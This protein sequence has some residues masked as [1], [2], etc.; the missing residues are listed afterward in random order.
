MIKKIFVTTVKSIASLFTGMGVTLK[1]FF[2]KPVTMQYPEEKVPMTERYRGAVCLVIDEKTGKHRCIACMTCI[3]TC[4]NYS[5]SL[6]GAVDENKKR[7]PTKFNLELGQ[8]MFCG[9]C[10]E[11]CPTKAL[12][13]NKEY[14]NASYTRKGLKRSLLP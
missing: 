12:E 5:L 2:K 6:E 14:E 9:L 10:V 11:V 8:C 4:P 7:Y 13:M 1:Y 3:R